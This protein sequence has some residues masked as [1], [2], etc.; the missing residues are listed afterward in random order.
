MRY[1]TSIPH[2]SV[3]PIPALAL[4]N[5]HIG[6]GARLAE[7]LRG[8]VPAKVRSSVCRASRIH[9]GQAVVDILQVRVAPR[10]RPVNAIVHLHGS[11]YAGDICSSVGGS[12]VD[13]AELRT[14]VPQTLGSRVRAITIKLVAPAFNVSLVNRPLGLLDIRPGVHDDRASDAATN[15]MG[16]SGAVGVFEFSLNKAG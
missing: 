10:V 7:N 3:Q 4:R 8:A 1:V 6:I 5:A 13:A 14:Q 9:L 12:D 15:G 16:D 11:G 2:G